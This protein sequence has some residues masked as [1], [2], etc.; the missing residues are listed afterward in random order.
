MTD[1]FENSTQIGG[2]NFEGVSSGMVEIKGVHANTSAG[3][4]I[5]GRDKI[6]INYYYAE[7][8]PPPPA[9]TDPAKP[10]K[11][12]L[13]SPYRGLYHFGPD[14]AGIFFG[15][16][17]FTRKLVELVQ[18]QN[19]IAVLGASGSGKSSVVLAGLAPPWLPL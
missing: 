13:L 6:I 3:G 2:V 15:R 18:A 14:D 19:F 12:A 17:V 5:T 11:I 4:D 10:A 9:E 8:L 7:R 1:E 16:G